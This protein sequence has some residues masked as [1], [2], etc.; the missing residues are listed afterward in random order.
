MLVAVIC[1]AIGIAA[2]GA[3]IGWFAFRRTRA[4]KR[5]RTTARVVG[6]IGRPEDDLRA[7]VVRFT[8]ADGE[9]RTETDRFYS[10]FAAGNV[11]SVIDVVV[12]RPGADGSP[13][14]VRI[15]RQADPTFLANALLAAAGVAFLLA[16]MFILMQATL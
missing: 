10:N 13:G 14:R 2:I 8:D 1:I 16:G 11:G 12:D 15:P 6:S 3:A 4:A 7:M 9:I 5:Y